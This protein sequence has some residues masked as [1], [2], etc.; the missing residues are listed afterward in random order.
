MTRGRSIALLGFVC[1]VTILRVWNTHHLFSPTYDEPIHVAAGYEYLAE[2][3]YS[4]DVQHPPLA[5]LFFAW[6]LRHARLTGGDGLEHYAQVYEGAGQYMEGVATSRRGNLVFVLLAI[7]AVTLWARSLFGTPTAL[8]AGALFALLPPVL[9]HGGLATTDMAGAAAFP[10]AMLAM[11]QWVTSPSWRRTLFL[12]VAIAVGLLSKFSF[13][14]FF[15]IGAIAVMASKRRFPAAKGIAAHLLAFLLVWMVYLGEYGRMDHVDA[16]AGRI[17][18]ELF[19][20]PAI[21]GVALPAPAFFLGLMQVK[22]HDRV[23]HAAYFMGNMREKGWWYYFPVIVA[24]K[25]P[26]PFLAL[27]GAGAWLAVRRRRHRHLVVIAVAILASTMTSHINLGARHILPIFAPLSLLAAYAVMTAWQEGKRGRWLVAPLCLWLGV[28]SAFAHP[29]YL[30]WMNV[31]AGSHPEK[32]VLDSNFDWGQD[33]VRL[34]HECQ[35]RGVTSLGIRLFGKADLGRIGLPP[36]HPIEDFHALPGWYAVSESEVVLT[37]LAD[38][39]ALFWLTDG[40]KFIRV[41][42]TVR[43]YHVE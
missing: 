18:T 40:T 19:G 2:H 15:A 6:P 20:S 7:V 28:D 43:L 23:G 13:P 10:L 1:V 39:V 5:R 34:R 42:K 36:T 3:R 24:I 17:A 11:T 26:L 8:M 37:Q 29:D 25:T 16:D 14:L 4:I 38:P 27:A 35:R 31:L 12:A 32:I 33:M 21:S 9:A 30:P 22:R 41:G